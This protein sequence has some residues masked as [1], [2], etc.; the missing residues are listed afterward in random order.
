MPLFRFCPDCAHP[1]PTPPADPGRVVHQDCP[2]CGAIHY[3]NA[4]PTA[5]ALIVR[6]GRVLLARRA[7]E[8]FKDRWDIPGGFLEPWEDPLEGVKR[9]VLEETGLRIEPTE[10][11]GILV[12]TY[13]DPTLHTFNVYYLA[14][15]VEGQPRAA[16]DVAELR[17]FTPESLP[18]VA[19][20]SGREALK[21]W[22]EKV[23]R[24]PANDR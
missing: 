1:L 16:D 9:E 8:P 17:W 7:V 24:C 11:V 14:Q 3:K 10:I 2:A 12:D 20:E 19:F 21:R 23:H 15:V 13:D 4:K 22:T 5:S 6:D 18:D